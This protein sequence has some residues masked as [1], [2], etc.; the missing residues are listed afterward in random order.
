MVQRRALVSKKRQMRPKSVSFFCRMMRRRPRRTVAPPGTRA[1]EWQ[2]FQLRNI[3]K[4][5]QWRITM[6]R[7]RTAAGMGVA[8]SLGLL[9]GV[10][11]AEARGGF[12]GGGFGGGGGFHGGFG[13][14]GMAFF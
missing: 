6:R 7:I 4:V 10:S 5:A 11:A 1:R 2:A 8:L 13:G 9:L 3:L 12:G 14:G